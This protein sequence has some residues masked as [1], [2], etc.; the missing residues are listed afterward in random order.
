MQPNLWNVAHSL[1]KELTEAD[2]DHNELAK[3]SAYLNQIRHAADFFEWLAWMATPRV[4]EQLA[5]S[6]RT[7]YYYQQIN[8][9]CQALKGIDDTA[10]MAQTLAWAVR[11]M[12]YYPRAHPVTPEQATANRAANPAPQRQSASPMPAGE[13][14]KA[15]STP[16]LAIKDLRPGLELTG[17]VKRIENYGAFV[18][19]GVGRDGLI[20]V[21]RLAAGYVASVGEVVTVGQRVTVWVYE[22]DEKAGRIGLT[23]LRPKPAVQQEMQPKPAAQP[24]KPPQQAAPPPVVTPRPAPPARPPA[25]QVTA[26][27]QVQEGV[28]VKGMVRKIE[29][30]R[31]IVEI[32]LDEAASLT[33]DRLPGKPTDPDEVA[34]R[35]PAGTA[36]EAQ[37]VSINRR[38][39]VQL[40]LAAG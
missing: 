9:A 2:T 35:W 30:N 38:G 20:H 26:S 39:R 19:I 36:L 25:I 31:I 12:R 34:E 40:T 21:S 4:S 18:D 8:Q 33:F 37:V 29:N 16:R 17:T 23:L 7:P 22:V 27:E 1:A 13:T 32:G 15:A 10:E 24:V 3:A 28:W 11:L 5:R 14:A 6:K